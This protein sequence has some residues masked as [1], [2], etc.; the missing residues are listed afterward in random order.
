MG[1]AGALGN[2]QTH[3][4][5]SDDEDVIEAERLDDV[6]RALPGAISSLTAAIETLE[7]LAT[8]KV[9]QSSDLRT[10]EFEEVE[11][12]DH[13]KTLLLDLVRAEH[14]VPL[15][16]RIKFIISETMNC[17]PSIIHEGLPGGLTT[18]L[19]DVESLDDARMLRTGK[20]PGGWTNFSITPRGFKYAQWLQERT[21]EPLAR[22]AD[23][24][25][26]YIDSQAF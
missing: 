1:Y 9:R 20:T 7:K 23:Q 18:N 26:N 13:Q 24:V 25:R 17:P 12:L 4:I 6:K 19:A 3:A 5:T 11:L 22:V 10:A 2:W 8:A 16:R 15:D 14:S 21:S